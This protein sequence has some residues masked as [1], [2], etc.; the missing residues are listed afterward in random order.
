[1]VKLLIIAYPDA[2]HLQNNNGITL[3]NLALANESASEAVVALLEPPQI[4]QA[5]EDQKLHT[6]VERCTGA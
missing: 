3:L 6:I 1:M 4:E 2:L 5:T